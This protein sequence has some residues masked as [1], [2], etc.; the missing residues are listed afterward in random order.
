MA[1]SRFEITFLAKSVAASFRFRASLGK[2][3]SK[4]K[5]RLPSSFCVTKG[6]WIPEAQRD[7]H[8]QQDQ[9]AEGRNEDAEEPQSVP[10]EHL[11]FSVWGWL[12]PGEQGDMHARRR[13][14]RR[15]GRP[16]IDGL[17]EHYVVKSECIVPL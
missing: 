14:R 10:E 9:G 6:I 13:S 16:V 7:D 15:I 11:E 17:R 12:R 2:V 4:P 5:P 1:S 3:G 8:K